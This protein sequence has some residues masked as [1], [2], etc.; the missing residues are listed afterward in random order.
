MAL[1]LFMRHKETKATTPGVGASRQGTNRHLHMLLVDINGN[2]LG[3]G[4]L[5]LRTAHAPRLLG[6][7]FSRTL[8][9]QAGIQQEDCPLSEDEHSLTDW[10]YFRVDRSLIFILVARLRFEIRHF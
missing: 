1:V 9:L 10:I 6:H 5:R 7:I 3:F 8:L 2:L 4:G